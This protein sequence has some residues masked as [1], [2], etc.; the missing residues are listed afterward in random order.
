MQK[1]HLKE[2]GVGKLVVAMAADPNETQENR[3]L[4]KQVGRFPPAPRARSR[5]RGSFSGIACRREERNTMGVKVFVAC[6]SFM[7]NIFRSSPNVR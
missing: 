1:N 4:I 6:V 7:Y 5:A 2:S 3:E